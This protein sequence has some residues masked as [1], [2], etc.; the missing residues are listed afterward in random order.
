MS[1]GSLGPTPAKKQTAHMSDL[2]LGTPTWALHQTPS[3]P[4]GSTWPPLSSSWG[5]AVC[6]EAALGRPPFGGQGAPP[7]RDARDVGC[8]G[9]P[10]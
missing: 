1:G 6:R 8:T 9:S 3:P 7:R 10:L 2:A 4:R 5:S